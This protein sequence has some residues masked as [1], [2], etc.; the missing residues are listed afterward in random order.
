[1]VLLSRVPDPPPEVTAWLTGE[2]RPQ[3]HLQGRLENR[4]GEGQMFHIYHAG[5]LA[6][7]MKGRVLPGGVA[8]WLGHVKEDDLFIVVG[9]LIFTKGAT[10]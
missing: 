2:K 8:Q 4:D 3:A 9:P 10:P 6:T 1:M 5:V 7:D